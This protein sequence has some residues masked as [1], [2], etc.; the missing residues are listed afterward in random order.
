MARGLRGSLSVIL[1]LWISAVIGDGKALRVLRNRETNCSQAGIACTIHE[2][3]CLDFSWLRP[4]DWTP[5]APSSLEVKPVLGM[6]DRGQSVPVL[7]INWT[8]SADS[9]IRNLQGVEVE[10]IQISTSRQNCVQFH[11]LEQFPKQ[12]NFENK[13]WRFSFKDFE[14]EHSQTYLVSVQNLPRLSDVN[15]LAKTVTVPSCSNQTLMTDSCCQHGY[16]WK[17]NISIERIGDEL[18]VSFDPWDEADF[19]RIQVKNIK[20]SRL[21]RNMEIK[22]VNNALRLNASCFVTGIS[23][24][25]WFRVQLWAVTPFCSSDCI[26][27]DFALDCPPVTET[28]PET[29]TPPPGP[30]RL[31]R[32]WASVAAAIILAFIA[33][34]LLCCVRRKEP[35]KSDNEKETP[36]ILPVVKKV[37]LVYSADSSLYVNVVI[38]LADFLKVAWGMEV[39]LD[40]QH[41]SDIGVAG[42]LTWLSRQ[43]ADI[44]KTK[45]TI[46]VLCSRGAQEK[47]KAMQTR[48]KPRVSLRQDRENLLGD[49][50]TAALSLIVPDFQKGLHYERYVV[51]YFDQLSNSADVPSLFNICPLYNLTQDLQDVF[52]RIQRQERHQPSVEFSAPQE[53]APGYESLKKAV[54]R[55]KTWQEK[56]LDWFENECSMKPAEDRRDEYEEETEESLTRRVNPVISYCEGPVTMVIPKINEP[57]R[58]EAVKPMIVDGPLSVQ[59]QTVLCRDGASLQTVHPLSDPWDALIQQQRPLFEE[60]GLVGDRNGFI[61]RDPAPYLQQ[62][63][64]EEALE[65]ASV[66]LFEMFRRNSVDAVE[67]SF[68]NEP[69]VE[70]PNKPLEHS[71]EGYLSWNSAGKTGASQKVP[72]MLAQQN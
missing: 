1:C 67:M 42:A 50:F 19:Y 28:T 65:E 59:V 32:I 63:F 6:D 14:V 46:L 71:D 64:S 61:V 27:K 51:A 25:C 7:E 70:V 8:L 26:R 58:S 31:A 2:S 54:S 40:Q 43:K 45:G 11:F 34:A 3:S 52:F 49:L 20:I 55:C 48:E 18:L 69:S 33:L 72:L 35:D 9:S 44:E 38:K 12:V 47:W 37:W 68:R 5:S 16:C 13:P 24:L 23:P 39:I 10:V 4:Y 15:S 53:L 60:R 17:P 36:A 56:H 30:T 22:P 41:L 62:D 29:T 21:N 66:R 57:H